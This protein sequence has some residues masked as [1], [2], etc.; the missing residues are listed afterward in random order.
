M[1]LNN[2]WS[3]KEDIKESS[4]KS[5]EQILNDLKSKIEEYKHKELPDTGRLK[6][7][8]N[9]E[10]R[11]NNYI[12]SF[13]ASLLNAKNHLNTRSLYS[14]TT[15]DYADK[16]RLYFTYLHGV[17]NFIY[18]ELK[19]LLNPLIEYHINHKKTILSKNFLYNVATTQES[20]SNNREK[21]LIYDDNF[22]T[23]TKNADFMAKF[24]ENNDFQ[25]LSDYIGNYIQQI[26]DDYEKEINE[27]KETSKFYI[28]EKDEK[29][30]ITTIFSKNNW[31]TFYI[32]D[33]HRIYPATE[34][35][36]VNK[37]AYSLA[38][39]DPTKFPE[40]KEWDI[41]TKEETTEQ[42][43][44]NIKNALEKSPEEKLEEI[45]ND[46]RGK[47]DWYKKI[48]ID[49]K[50]M[51]SPYREKLYTSESQRM[52]DDDIVQN[53]EKV[54]ESFYWTI[55]KSIWEEKWEQ[56]NIWPNTYK[57]IKKDPEIREKVEEL[58]RPLVIYH[59]ENIKTELKKDFII[60]TILYNWSILNTNDEQYYES[61]ICWEEKISDKKVSDKK[62]LRIDSI[63]KY[64]NDN[65]YDWLSEY[66]KEYVEK[67]KEKYEKELSEKDEKLNEA[68]KTY[69]LDENDNS[70]TIVTWT[71]MFYKITKKGTVIPMWEDKYYMK[72]Y[73]DLKPLKEF[74]G[75]DW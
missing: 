26:I 23:N 14:K 36:K 2:I 62:V 37:E 58:I 66:I 31:K 42:T 44:K 25:G 52:T 34:R 40:F 13:C 21:S 20:I 22:T 8:I 18:D 70:I 75:T 57:S 72:R 12:N 16:E 35:G 60:N 71:W 7:L 73:R 48:P 5:L 1:A 33:D 47:I 3:T 45:L 49:I 30:G 38:L 29:Q 53:I 64:I 11:Y 63:A 51:I 43:N 50:N 55:L 46:L 4:E 54:S 9:N 69:I 74:D 28:F 41:L 61:L 24:I 15:F 27:L 17:P 59:T 65:D 68:T 6:G 10:E 39:K 19:D 67:I 32:Q 56:K